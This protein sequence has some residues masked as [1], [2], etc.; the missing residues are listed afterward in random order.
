MINLTAVVPVQLAGKRLDQTLAILFPDYSRSRLA[1]FTQQGFVT[2]NGALKKPRDKVIGGEIIEI[3]ADLPE[4]SHWQA[5]AIPLEIIY[6]DEAILV[7]NK[8]IGLV[9]HPAAGNRDHTLVN[10]LLHHA[11]ALAQIPRAGIVHRLDKDTSGLLVVAKTL[12]AHAHLIKQLQARTVTREYAAIV[13][14]N[15]IAG[16]TIDAPIGRHPMQRQ[17][18]AVLDSGKPAITHYRISERFPAHTRLKIRLETG[19]THQ[20]RVHMAF[21]QHPLIGDATYGGRLLLPKQASE[22]LRQ[23]LREF[24]HQALHAERLGLLHPVTHEYQEWQSPLPK[25]MRMLLE[26]LREDASIVRG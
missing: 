16:G 12:S 23:A 26:A 5:Q 2:V 3:K 19:R 17:K 21:I 15:L 11:P 8:P 4:A 7:V 1:S 10:A 22:K 13:N 14:G 25:D 24:K 18:M 9:V 20:I 6:E